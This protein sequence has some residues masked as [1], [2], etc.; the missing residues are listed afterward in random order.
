MKSVLVALVIA[1][2]LVCGFSTLSAAELTLDNCIEMALTNRA[3]IVAVR[4]SEARAIANKRSALGAFLPNLNASYSYSNSKTTDYEIGP[5][6]G[7]FTT[8]PD[9]ERAGTNLG[10]SASMWGFNLPDWF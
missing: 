2:V 5:V 6:G 10:L 9:Q 8:E 3:S 7:P 1:V 4:G